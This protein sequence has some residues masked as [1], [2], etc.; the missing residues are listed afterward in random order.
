M[1]IA[2]GQCAGGALGAILMTFVGRRFASYRVGFKAWRRVGE[3]GLQM[4]AVSGI[5]AISLRLSDVVLGRLLGLSE[6]GVYNRASGLNGLIWNN[7]HL[8]IGR[9]VFVDYAELYRQGISLRARYLRTV[10]VVTAILWP[11][12][13]GM[14][15]LAKP[16]IVLVYGPIWIPAAFPLSL[17]A[18]ASMIQV[19]ITMTWE[20]FAATGQLKTQTRVEFIRAII[21]FMAFVLG[22]MISL[23]AAAGAR[24]L[25]SLFALLLYRP[26]L[27]RMTDTKL[28]D[29]LIIYFRS[30]VLT[31]LA[32]F[33]AILL[34]VS[35]SDVDTTSLLSLLGVVLSG[36]ILWSVGLACMRHS[37]VDE[38]RII[39][40]PLVSKSSLNYWIRY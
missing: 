35:S 19:A 28:S 31:L 9:V 20:L 8:V 34:R 17:L 38:L 25:D 2:Y 16:F 30:I 4:L 6:L 18:L 33:P 22:C 26:Y 13:G 5:S 37:L 36:L 24:I 11:A 32:V 39:M 14:A 3:F 15:V 21:A 7:I 23:Q 29:F 10:D 40:K 27:N 12:F 1:S